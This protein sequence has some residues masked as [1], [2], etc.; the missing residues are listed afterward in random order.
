MALTRPRGHVWSGVPC[1]LIAV[2]V[3]AAIQY[4]CVYIWQ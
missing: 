1:L 3:T 2:A 4:G